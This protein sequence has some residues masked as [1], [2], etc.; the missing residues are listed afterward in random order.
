MSDLGMYWLIHERIHRFLPYPI[1]NTGASAAIIHHINYIAND[2]DTSPSAVE[3][4]R[5]QNICFWI[6]SP[7]TF[8]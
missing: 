2:S 7:V 4:G 8:V 3:R 1:N 5:D 6:G